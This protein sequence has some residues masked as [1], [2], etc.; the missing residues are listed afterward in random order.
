MG[1]HTNRDL[2]IRRKKQKI[3]K[4]RHQARRK[5]KLQRAGGQMPRS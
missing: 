3:A 1:R 5:E 2:R 4:K